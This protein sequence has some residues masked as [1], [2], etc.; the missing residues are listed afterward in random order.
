MVLEQIN[1]GNTPND[2]GGD[3]LRDAFLKISRNFQ[4]LQ[5]ATLRGTNLGTA[6]AEVF[7]GTSSNSA[8]FRRLVAG[9]NIVIAQLDNTVDNFVD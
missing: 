9:D 2:G 5:G 4:T 3:S 7:A 6:G 1:V 8:N